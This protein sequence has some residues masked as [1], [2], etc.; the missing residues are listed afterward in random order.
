MSGC[1]SAHQPI[2]LADNR[3]QPGEPEVSV[4]D[5]IG[6]SVNE[7][8]YRPRSTRPDPVKVVQTVAHAP[9][10]GRLEDSDPELS[11]ALTRA[12]AWPT[13]RNHRRVA[14]IYQGHGILDLAYDQLKLAERLAPRDAATHDSLARLWRTWGLQEFGLGAAYRAVTYAPASPQ[15]HN[16]LGTLLQSL[17]QHAEA[18]RAYGRALGLDPQA[19]YVLNNLCYLSFVEQDF[20]AAAEMCQAALSADPTLTETHNNLALV[21]FATDR[22]ALAWQELQAGGAVWTALYNL[23]IAHMARGEYL[24]AAA[25]FAAASEEN[26]RWAAPRS[27]AKQAIARASSR[28]ARPVASERA[29]TW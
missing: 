7:E 13:P 29:R 3:I 5:P 28:P 11:L 20:D 21:Y 22:N 24:D 10:A 6:L 14:E 12:Q 9:A 1:A 2:E 27:R 4:G 8:L 19:T 16:T 18:R 25:V 26:P 23:G 17:G 15:A